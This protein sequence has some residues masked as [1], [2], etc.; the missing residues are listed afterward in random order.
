MPL[1]RMIIKKGKKDKMNKKGRDFVIATNAFSHCIQAIKA[2]EIKS[3]KLKGA[4]TMLLLYL[5]FNPEGLTNTE[6]V[7]C[8]KMDKAAVSRSLAELAKGKFI[9]F[10][11]RNGKS[12]YGAH[13]VLTTTGKEV[14]EHIVEKI[15]KVLTKALGHLSAE[16]KKS[17]VVN[18]TTVAS[19]MLEI[20]E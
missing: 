20:V 3:T 10:E 7:E 6:L 1:I 19:A 15:G 18:M 13:A 8:S 14:T 17:F 2:E 12:R 16:E 9:R 5:G 11:Y 4:E